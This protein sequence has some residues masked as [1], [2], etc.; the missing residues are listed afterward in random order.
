MAT[1]TADRSLRTSIT[2]P[3]LTNP[4]FS[5]T[6]SM[7]SLATRVPG[8]ISVSASGSAFTTWTRTA[9]GCALAA[10]A[11]LSPG[12]PPG[13]PSRPPP[14]SANTCISFGAAMAATAMTTSVQ[15]MK[16]RKPTPMTSML[17]ER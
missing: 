8:E 14:R 12:P 3:R 1:I 4:A 6:T 17:S 5:L 13:P 16:R 9:G 10:A 7:R 11:P 2:E 15:R